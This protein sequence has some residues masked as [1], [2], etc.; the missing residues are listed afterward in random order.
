MPFLVV[1][2]NGYWFHRTNRMQTQ[3]GWKMIKH[4]FERY[5]TTYAAHQKFQS[6]SRRSVKLERLERIRRM[7]DLK[8]RLHTFFVE[9]FITCE[10]YIIV[11]A[12]L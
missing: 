12:K 6:V 1:Y 11:C 4:G 10:T 3:F 8:W 5:V 9:N 2:D 7:F